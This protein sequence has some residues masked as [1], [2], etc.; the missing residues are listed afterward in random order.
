MNQNHLFKKITKPI[1]ICLCLLS[2]LFPVISFAADS[3]CATVKIEISQ[4]LTLERQG[5]EAHMRIN[6]G[7]TNISLETL[8]N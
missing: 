4:E 2:L 7:L 3:L 6:N 1:Y 5:F 8:P